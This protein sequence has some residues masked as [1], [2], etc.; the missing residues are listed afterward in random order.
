MCVYKLYARF[1]RTSEWSGRKKIIMLATDVTG[2][3][4]TIYIS[5]IINFIGWH[6]QR[7]AS[8][9]IERH[10]NRI[11]STPPPSWRLAA[12][13]LFIIILLWKIHFVSRLFLYLHFFFLTVF[14]FPALPDYTIYSAICLRP[15]IFSPVFPMHVAPGRSPVFKVLRLP[16]S[17][18]NPSKT[19]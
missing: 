7:M 4:L 1:I 12:F 11:S 16:C 6:E 8:G 5:K 15:D 10:A 9:H 13:Q 17:D 18:R 3:S 2:C 19:Q 14:L